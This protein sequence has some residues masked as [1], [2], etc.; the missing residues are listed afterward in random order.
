MTR[1]YISIRP[2]PG[3]RSELL[4][5][6]ERVEALTAAR[7]LPGFIAA[8]IQVPIAG[9]EHVLVWSSWASPEHH[10]R[11]LAGPAYEQLLREIGDLSAE[12]P[13]VRVYRVVEAVQA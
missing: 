13:T 12:P 7:N 9:D 1:S 10:D 3:R 8:E 4:Q 6:L 2:Q 11:W 5:V